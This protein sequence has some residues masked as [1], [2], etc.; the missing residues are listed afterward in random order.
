MEGGG[1]ERREGG[2]GEG[3]RLNPLFCPLVHFLQHQVLCC[4]WLQAK[5]ITGEIDTLLSTVD[6][7]RE[8]GRRRWSERRG[9]GGDVSGWSLRIYHQALHPLIIE[10]LYF[11]SS[12]YR[13]PFALMSSSRRSAILGTLNFDLIPA[14]L[15]L[16][17]NSCATQGSARSV[18]SC[19][20]RPLRN[21]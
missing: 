3:G 18:P 11:Y 4:L 12:P 14:S 9:G 16:L 1:E 5:G 6:A 19:M 2:G 13:R 20:A 7:C 15:S 21:P 8:G 10:S 17:S